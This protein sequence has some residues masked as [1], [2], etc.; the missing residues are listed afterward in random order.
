ERAIEYTYDA[1]GRQV[2][3][4]VTDADGERHCLR[5]WNGRQ[6]LEEW[7]DGRLSR[8]FV[9][10]ARV[11]EPVMLTRHSPAGEERVFYTFNGRGFAP[12]LV[13]SRGSSAERYRYDVFRQP[14]LSERDGRPVEGL[15][16]SPLGNPF[17]IAG[18]IWDGDVNSFQAL[19]NSYDPL[20]GQYPD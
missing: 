12:G 16:S 6:L 3:R 19:G 9:Y 2:T 14:F 18:S 11:N 7:E 17:F 10:G 5:V 15:S 1:F 20:T 8:S 13:D 4:R